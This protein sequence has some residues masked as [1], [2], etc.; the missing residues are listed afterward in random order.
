MQEISRLSFFRWANLQTAACLTTLVTSV[1]QAFFIPLACSNLIV[2]H[3][4]S[5]RFN[6]ND[7][8][9]EMDC[10]PFAASPLWKHIHCLFGKSFEI[11][12]SR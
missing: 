6:S 1:V 4:D 9:L 7:F 3:I 5:S 2:I 12:D 11:V 8:A 10:Q